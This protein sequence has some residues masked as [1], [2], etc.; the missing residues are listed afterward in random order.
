MTKHYELGLY[1]RYVAGEG[2]SDGSTH[3]FEYDRDP[4]AERAVAAWE[5]V[6]AVCAEECLFA[7]ALWE[8]SSAL[9][10]PLSK[11]LMAVSDGIDVRE[12]AVD[13]VPA[14]Q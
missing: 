4:A 14:S 5:R 1:R 13:A 11:L 6:R 12:E 8:Y 2:I 9:S 3:W 10:K 7:V